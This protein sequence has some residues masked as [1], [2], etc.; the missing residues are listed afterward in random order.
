MSAV[1]H[2][3][4][5]AGEIVGSLGGDVVEVDAM[6]NG[7]HDGEEQGSESNDLMGTDVG[8]EGDIVVEDGFS[9]VRDEVSG[10]GEEEDRVRPHHARGS[11]SSDGH[12]K[13]SNSP[14]ARIL[15]FYRVIVGSLHEDASSDKHE[16]SE[17]EYLEPLVLNVAHKHS[18]VS[19]KC[20]LRIRSLLHR[21][22]NG[23]LMGVQG[24]LNT[25]R[26]WVS[27]GSPTVGLD[28]GTSGTSWGSFT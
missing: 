24:C 11:T 21:N 4:E 6:T 9:K 20:G 16:K 26:A 7:V 23:R 12:S 17:V 19:S 5:D 14:Q 10:H 28:D 18:N 1:V 25:F 3:S 8:I 13:T 2:F 27:L 15:S 22:V